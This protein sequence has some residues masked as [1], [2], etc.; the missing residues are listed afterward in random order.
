MT[1]QLSVCFVWH[2]HQPL[3]KDRLADKYLMPWVRLHALKDYLDMPL[4]LEDYPKIRQTFN[5]VPSLIEQINDYAHNNA[6]DRE[7]DLLN[8]D[9]NSYSNVDKLYILNNSFHAE[10]ETQIKIYPYYYQLYK[11]KMNLLKNNFKVEE[12]IGDFNPQEYF[13]ML[14]WF[15][16]CWF[17][18]LW[19][20]SYSELKS[21]VDKGKDF[22]QEDRQNLIKC[23]QKILKEVIPTYKRLQEKGQIEVITTPYYHP[24][25]PLLIDTNSAVLANTYTSLPQKCYLFPKDAQ[26]QIKKACD[27]YEKSFGCKPK[28]MWPSEMSVSVQALNLIAKEGFEWVVLNEGLLT[29]STD[30]QIIR[31]ENGNLVNAETICQPYKLKNERLRY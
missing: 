31:D 30:K 25:L 4:I 10:L 9:F 7:L 22:N 23:Q 15:N 20:E 26:A 27:L 3:Y 2:M 14:M 11:K 29:K 21:L 6:S 16:L 18:N 5:L 17:D 12:I 28:G 8:K 24:I 1:E 13:D 19:L